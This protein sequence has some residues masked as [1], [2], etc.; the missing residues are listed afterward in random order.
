MPWVRLH[1]TSPTAGA[2]LAWKSLDVTNPGPLYAIR[3]LYAT[4]TGSARYQH[5][6]SNTSIHVQQYNKHNC[7][8]ANTV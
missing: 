4:P 1:P 7:A 8:A 6:A 3:H 2:Q 5:A